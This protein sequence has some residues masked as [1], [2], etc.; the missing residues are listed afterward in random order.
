[1][2]YAFPQS[3]KMLALIAR[4]FRLLGEPYRLR[5]LQMLESQERTVGNIVRLLD[6][7]QPNVSK[8][9][10]MLHD[11]GL[12]SRRREGTSI[13]YGIADPMVIQLCEIV[14]RSTAER[15]REEFDDLNVV[16]VSSKR[17][18]VQVEPRKTGRFG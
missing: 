10:Q 18:K 17:T 3:D 14:C 2:T 6:G 13:Y 16:P 15:A 1:M 7:N 8:H 11:G 4:R 9:L 12:V 5:I